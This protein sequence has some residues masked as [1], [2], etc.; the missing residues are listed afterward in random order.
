MMLL[1]LPDDRKPLHEYAVAF[2]AL[3]RLNFINNLYFFE[4]STG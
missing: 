1:L 2:F 4:Q 3:A